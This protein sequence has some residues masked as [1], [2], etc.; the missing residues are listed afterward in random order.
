MKIK[1]NIENYGQKLIHYQNIKQIK[2][3]NLN[4]FKN[5]LYIQL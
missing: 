1:T 4:W 3:Y 5:L 2:I